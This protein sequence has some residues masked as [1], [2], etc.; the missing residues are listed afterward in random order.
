MPTIS[1]KAKGR[2]ITNITAVRKL[3]LRVTEQTSA[4]G[5][6][7]FMCI[8][9]AITNCAEIMLEGLE[10][11]KILAPKRGEFVLGGDN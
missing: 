3:A 1:H 4:P 11:E 10:E 8:A 6:I 9:L 5:D 7:A 2:I